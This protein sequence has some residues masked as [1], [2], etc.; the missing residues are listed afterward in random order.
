MKFGIFSDLHLDFAPWELTVDPD[1]FY[2]NA[3]DT[4]PD[5]QIRDAFHFQFKDKIF[6]ITCIFKINYSKRIII[7]FLLLIKFLR[8][9]HF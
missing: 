3:G 1:V 4:H 6:F 2:L 9:L 5:V 8:I 7:H